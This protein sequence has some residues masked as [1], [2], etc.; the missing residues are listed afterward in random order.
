VSDSP[1]RRSFLFGRQATPDDQ[2]S[3]FLAKLGRACRGSVKLI[4]EHQA[5]LNPLQ[6][7]DVIQARRICQAHE[8]VLALEGLPLPLVDQSRHTLWVQ[9]GSAWGSLLPLGDTGLWRVDAGCPMAVAQAAGLLGSQWPTH[10]TNVAQWFAQACRQQPLQQTGLSDH[11][12]SIDWMLPDGTIEVFGAFGTSDSQPLR[13]LA[14]QKIVP[15]LFEL[16]MSPELQ[17]TAQSGVWP[18][19]YH[20][21][22]LM[23]PEAVN[24]AHCFVGHGGS[25]GWLVAVTFKHTAQPMEPN[26]AHRTAGEH[27]TQSTEGAAL[28]M[29]QALEIDQ[30]I[31]CTVDPDRVLLS[32][33]QQTE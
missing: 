5:H 15:K 9:A 14:A 2:W 22:A 28:A 24:L 27:N 4:A 13:S 12:V 31:K 30:A 23:D 19:Q 32:T 33:P 18:L 26:A 8:V 6:L 21:D 1:L 25:L 29:S 17:V 10:M 16:S 20:L 3:A 11:V 7:D